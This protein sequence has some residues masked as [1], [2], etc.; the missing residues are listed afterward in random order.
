MADQSY[1]FFNSLIDVDLIKVDQN[2]AQTY[3][4]AIANKEQML[5]TTTLFTTFDA[6]IY[7]QYFSPEDPVS[8]ARYTVYKRRPD[9]TYYDFVCVMTDGEYVFY[10]YNI[11]NH[12]YYHYMCYIEV[13]TS[14]GPIYTIYSTRNETGGL[15]YVETNWDE[16]SICDIV[17]NE[18][19]ENG[20]ISYSKSGPI[21]RL[22]VNLDSEDLTQNTSVTVWDTLGK[23]PKISIGQKDYMS[24]TVTCNLGQVTE[25][26]RYGLR[27]LTGRTV[28][29]YTEKQELTENPYAR[30]MQKFNDWREFVNN[31]NMKLL[32][33]IKGNNWVVQITENPTADIDV[34]PWNMPT[35][36]SFDWVEIED[37]EGLAIIKIGTDPNKVVLP[38]GPQEEESSASTISTYSNRARSGDSSMNGVVRRIKKN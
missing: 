4:E 11:N 14:E 22:K 5:A 25:Y 19:D 15:D 9:Q 36:I 6:T 32:K 18:P 13:E 2:I 21:W 17:E 38:Y 26:T 1:V 34:R 27:D 29:D 31:G 33:D 3:E 24:G 12:N 23:Y 20:V 30:E 10:D 16:W 28:Y 37:T 35:T 8:G 7:A